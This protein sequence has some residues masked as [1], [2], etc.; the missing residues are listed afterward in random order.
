MKL[1]Q[2]TSYFKR[3][4]FAVYRTSLLFLRLHKNI[5]LAHFSHSITSPYSELH[6]IRTVI[7]LKI[8]FISNYIGGINAMRSTL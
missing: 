3:G 8:V 6:T 1:F 7:R 5:S 4:Y 2:V